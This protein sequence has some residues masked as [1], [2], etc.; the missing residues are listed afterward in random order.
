MF[1][2]NDRS[3]IQIEYGNIVLHSPKVIMDLEILP[4]PR[5]QA[6]T[7]QLEFTSP[8]KARSFAFLNSQYELSLE[9]ISLCFSCKKKILNLSM[10][11]WRK[12]IHC[13]RNL[14][15]HICSINE[16]ISFGTLESLIRSNYGAIHTPTIIF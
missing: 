7:S 12:M 1:P 15:V 13:E 3:S 8:S 2:L 14:M 16:V 10:N 5:N 9:F 11:F 6:S 4:I